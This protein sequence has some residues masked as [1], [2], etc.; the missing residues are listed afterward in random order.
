M[1]KAIKILAFDSSS[2][3][4]GWALL[5]TTLRGGKI[6]LK[7]FDHFKIRAK[8]GKKTRSIPER[9]DEFSHEIMALLSRHKPDYVAFEEHHINRINAA[10]VLLKFMGVGLQLAYQCTGKDPIE[11]SPREIRTQLKINWMSRDIAKEMVKQEVEEFFGIT[12]EIDDES[13]AIA[14]AMASAG[15]VR[16][17]EGR[18]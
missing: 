2:G 3:V 8:V 9:L 12:V 4:T 1:A 13:D 14:L 5:T 16:I 15:K 18:K 17:L 6:K 10:K 7:E 11:L